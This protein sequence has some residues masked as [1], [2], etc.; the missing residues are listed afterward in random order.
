[1]GR[2]KQRCGQYEKRSDVYS[3]KYGTVFKL[4]CEAQ[5]RRYSIC[6][7]EETEGANI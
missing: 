1:M 7:E 3:I 6:E 2:W 4:K 5:Q